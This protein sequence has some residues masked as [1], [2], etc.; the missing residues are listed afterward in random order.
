MFV[1]TGLICVMKMVIWVQI[2]CSLYVIE[3]GCIYFSFQITNNE[4]F[5]V[6]GLKYSGE[7]TKGAC[8]VPKRAMDVM[9]GEVN[10]VLQLCDS[11]VIPITWQVPRKVSVIV[12]FY[13]VKWKHWE[14]NQ[15]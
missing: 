7:Q 10:R 6:E 13:E 12:T 14:K 5:I 1:L 2:F 9:Q 3:F 8:L 4:P 15:L 11:S